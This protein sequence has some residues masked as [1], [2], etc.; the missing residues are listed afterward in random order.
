MNRTSPVGRHG[1]YPVRWPIL[2]RSAE[3]LAEGTVVDLTRIGWRVAGS[4]PVRPGMHLEL[5]LVVPQRSEPV[6]VERATVLWVH[7]CEF[8][9]EV[10]RMEAADDT[11]V[12]QFLKQKLAV[13]MMSSIVDVE[14]SR[15]AEHVPASTEEAPPSSNGCEFL[16][17]M[18][19][20][21][22]A[23]M[24]DVEDQVIL[25]YMAEQGCTEANARAAYDRFMQQVWQPALRILDGMV[26]QTAERFPGANLTSNN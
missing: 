18:W 12:Q 10:D 7:G 24:K 19:I 15:V 2:Y 25:S 14:P 22:Q 8:A 3:F 5:E 6:R 13:P 4:M 26:I 23:N 1:R 20:T 11:W 16:P 9:I 17:R 21:V